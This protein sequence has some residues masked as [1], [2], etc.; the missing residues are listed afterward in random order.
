MANW[1]WDEILLTCDL[2]AQNDWKELR[3][4]SP[5][6]VELSQFLRAQV[7]SAVL[8][9]DPEFRNVNGV[10]RKTTDIMTAHPAYSRARTKG[11][12]TTREVVSA[13]LAYP[14]F[15][16]HASVE[17]REA[18]SLARREDQ[19]FM[20][21]AEDEP[22]AVEGRVMERLIRVRERDPK[23]RQEKILKS[24]ALHGRLA[25]EVCTFD[26]EQTYGVLGSGYVQVHHVVPLHSS[27]PVETT[28]DGLVVVCAN[29][30][31]MLHRGPTWRTPS[32]L[33]ALLANPITD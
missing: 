20:F 33:R 30:H 18:G 6:V 5:Q 2:V 15:H 22:V 29:C 13:Y 32:E 11:G 24:R 27:G 26:F 21:Q 19:D 4:T 31:V 16:H 25:C 9:N 17:L 10:S 1:K 23:L 3:P 8:L 28:L 12:R 7:S 14:I